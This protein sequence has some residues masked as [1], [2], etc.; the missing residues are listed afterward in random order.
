MPPPLQAYTPAQPRTAETTMPRA[1][2]SAK[3]KPAKTASKG[4]K[5]S[6]LTRARLLDAA[7]HVFREKGYALTRLSDI[8]KRANTPV[9]AIYYYFASREEIV[10]RVLEIANER[11]LQRV[12]GAVA[13]LPPGASIEQKLSAA[14]RGHFEIVLLAD[15][16]ARAHMRIFDQIPAA[17]QKQFRAVLDQTA[18]TWRELLAEGRASGAIREDLD[19][20]VVRQL[21]LGMINW[22][23]EWYQPGGRLSIEEIAQQTSRLLFHGIAAA[24]P[25]A[26]HRRAVKTAR[27]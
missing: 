14:V 2:P 22:S 16:Y 25:R 20:S 19:L 6:E 11:T 4:P 12:R 18:E 15:P 17:I 1:R 3:S 5:K 26:V 23:V 13:E 7:A 21:L 8:A 24:R 9:S 10:V 27:T